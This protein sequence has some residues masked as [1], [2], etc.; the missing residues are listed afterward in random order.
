MS[1]RKRITLADVFKRRGAEIEAEIEAQTAW[2]ATPEGRSWREAQDAHHRRME[3]ADAR[4]A[5]EHPP[6]DDDADAADEDD[7][8][9]HDANH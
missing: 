9:R 7:A 5:A 3:E 1:E 6:E 2:E 8:E 4:F